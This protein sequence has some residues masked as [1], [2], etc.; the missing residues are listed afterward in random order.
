MTI[1]F[2]KLLQKQSTII[3]LSVKKPKNP[4]LEWWGG[5]YFVIILGFYEKRTS[6]KWFP[7]LFNL[8]WIN[9]K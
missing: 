1:T 9:Q 6:T 7:V 4:I 3:Y 2:D 8:N 5:G